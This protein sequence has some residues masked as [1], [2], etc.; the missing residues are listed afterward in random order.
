MKRFLSMYRVEQKL[1][2]RTPD[3]ILFCLA[4]PLVVFVVIT[5][6]TGGKNAADSGL[7]GLSQILCKHRNTVQ[8]EQNLFKAEVAQAAAALFSK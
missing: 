2:L 5:M 6:I 8:I 1:F 4:M 3:V 7:T